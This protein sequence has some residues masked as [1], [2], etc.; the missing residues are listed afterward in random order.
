MCGL[1]GQPSIAAEAFAPRQVLC[2]HLTS[3]AETKFRGR[4][5]LFM[6][7]ML[8]SRSYRAL[9][10]LVS[11]SEGFCLE[12]LLGAIL[13]KAAEDMIVVACNIKLFFVQDFVKPL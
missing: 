2:N 1:L 6:S 12:G 4:K 10:M 9:A 3:R 8:V 11:T 13:F 7:G 5:A